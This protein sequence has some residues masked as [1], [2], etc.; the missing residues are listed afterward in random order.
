MYK[1]IKQHP[2]YL[3]VFRIFVV[4]LL[5][6]IVWV[7]ATFFY[8][9]YT[10]GQ[11]IHTTMQ[12]KKLKFKDEVKGVDF[13][14]KN[15]Q[16]KI[17]V[18][19]I[20]QGMKEEKIV[21]VEMYN[22]K[23][24]KIIHLSEDINKIALT[25]IEKLEKF[26]I[27]SYEM[28]PLGSNIA[29]I[30]YQDKFELNGN[31]YYVNLLMKLDE[32]TMNM[33]KNDIDGTLFLLISTMLIVFLSIF[34][35]IKSQYKKMLDKQNELMRSNINTLISLGG[36]IAK[37]DSDTSEHN[38]RV[39]YYSIKIA[40]QLKLPLEQLQA[41]IKGAFLHDIGKIAITDNILLK[42]GK[43]TQEEFE[44]MK[45]HVIS[46]IDIVA[47]DEWLSDAQKVI[48][49]HHEK[50]DGT[51]YPNRLKADDIPIEARIFAVADVFDALTSKRP[52]KEA[53]S[54]EKS[55]EILNNDAGSH[56]D[57]DIVKCFEDI[58]IEV[59]NAMQDKN[60]AELE[61]IFHNIL[62]PYFF[63]S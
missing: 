53:F 2:L 44:I 62:Q 17:L 42:P 63:E 32:K 23:K 18:D 54:L 11:D 30:Y 36:A 50:V 15:K 6:T 45:T 13:V 38:Y 21:F 1:K 12:E 10:I 48:L 49:N 3:F 26:A 25:R 43:L 28:W 52:Y 16:Y 19:E 58:H 22:E 35:I 40:E 56:F 8:Y 59:F 7:L 51:G 5:S 27:K 46:G 61:K 47:N 57:K 55:M 60:S 14:D 31:V 33:I 4:F 41:L 39:T 9:E 20:K 24:E 29:Y 37:R 34:P